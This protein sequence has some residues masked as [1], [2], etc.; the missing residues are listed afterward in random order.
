MARDVG[1]TILQAA[2]GI[3]S[4]NQNAQRLQIQT[5][6]LGE[7]IKN[8]NNNLQLQAENIR[9]K[10]ES[11]KIQQENAKAFQ[12]QVEAQR[13][14]AAARDEPLDPEMVQALLG[15]VTAEEPEARREAVAALGQFELTANIAATL[16]R[17][18]NVLGS[19][20]Q[21]NAAA[22]AD[23]DALKATAG[24]VRLVAQAVSRD[25]GTMGI[26]RFTSLARNVRSK[27]AAAQDPRVQ[28]YN[29]IF[30]QEG[31]QFNS[32]EAADKAIANLETR[33]GTFTSQV[34]TQG[35]DVRR[36]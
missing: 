35:A 8:A 24:S 32:V 13:A 25:A 31:V 6:Q 10:E 11:L 9:L 12:A 17:T 5:V 4:Q 7:Q 23:P 18:Y 20:M 36:I 16:S 26:N 15:A 3:V 29:K 30:L 2:Q 34:S 27:R 22:G 19:L 33:I 21:A 1:D 14:G 28:E